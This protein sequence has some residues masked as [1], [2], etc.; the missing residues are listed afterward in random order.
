MGHTTKTIVINLEMGQK[1]GAR[2]E[3]GGKKGYRRAG[4]KPSEWKT[5]MYEIV[6]EL[7]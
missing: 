4:R 2:A 7:T 3:T 1:I 5:Y 6:K